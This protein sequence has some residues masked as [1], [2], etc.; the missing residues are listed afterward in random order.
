MLAAAKLA[1]TPMLKM[2]VFMLAQGL[3]GA[4][5]SKERIRFGPFLCRIQT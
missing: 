3:S 5:V 4:N 2:A 1:N